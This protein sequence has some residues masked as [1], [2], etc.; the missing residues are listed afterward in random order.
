MCSGP[1]SIWLPLEFAHPLLPSDMEVPVAALAIL[2]L[3]E[4][5]FSQTCSASCESVF[6]SWVP[7]LWSWLG[8]Q[9]EV[10]PETATQG[11]PEEF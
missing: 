10:L 4:T 6:C 1:S 8:P 3:A 5:L 11:A 9:C 2:I 7:P